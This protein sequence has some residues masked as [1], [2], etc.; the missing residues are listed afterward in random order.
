MVVRTLEDPPDDINRLMPR[1]F[2]V[3]FLVEEDNVRWAIVAGM[4]N[5][6]LSSGSSI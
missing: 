4:Y 3:N 1:A 6:Q 2:N 5:A